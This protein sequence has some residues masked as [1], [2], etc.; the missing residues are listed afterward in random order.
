[1]T[2]NR[3]GM[4]ELAKDL[5]LSTP[6][7]KAVLNWLVAGFNCNNKRYIWVPHWLALNPQIFSQGAESVLEWLRKGVE[8]NDE[9][10]RG[11]HQR[12]TQDF[13]VAVI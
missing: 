12:A 4:S 6:K 8:N 3:D 9:R 1:M 7:G 5:E 11:P 13:R 2:V 10:F